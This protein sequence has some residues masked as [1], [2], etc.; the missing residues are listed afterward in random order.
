MD[1]HEM[2]QTD[3][4]SVRERKPRT[5]AVKANTVYIIAGVPAIRTHNGAQT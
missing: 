1:A 4:F 5:A 3:V 2:R